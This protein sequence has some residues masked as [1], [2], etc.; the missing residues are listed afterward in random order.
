MKLDLKKFINSAPKV[1]QCISLQER[2]PAFVAG[3]F[4]M[5][6]SYEVIDN[7]EFFLLKIVENALVPMH[8]QRCMGE[9]IQQHHLETEIAVCHNEKLAE[10]Y[11]SLYDVIVAKDSIVDLEAILVDNCHLYL[12]AFHQ[13]LDECEANQLKSSQYV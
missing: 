12:S 1:A 3:S 2:L 13:E 10:K 11:Q 4:E 6:F 5:E 8:C 9:F 7:G